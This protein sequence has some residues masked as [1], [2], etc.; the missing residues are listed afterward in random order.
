MSKY[1]QK[2][3]DHIE[4]NPNFIKEASRTFG[5]STIV[6]AVE[7]IKQSN[8]SYLAYTDNGREHT[9]V[10]AVSWAK[11]AEDHGAGEILLTSIDKDGT[12]NGFDLE[13]IKKVSDLVT[14]PVIAHGGAANIFHISASIKDA[15]ADA[16][17][18]ASILHYTVLNNNSS[19]VNNY[20]TEG[21]TEFLKKKGSFK[22]FGKENISKIK[23]QLSKTDIPLSFGF[24]NIPAFLII[25]PITTFMAKI[26]ANA[27]HRIDKK[28]VNKLFG[29][30]LLIVAT[31]FMY[32]YLNI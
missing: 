16:V 25:V 24:I 2:L 18:I 31:K 10:D 32:N 17:A 30:F 5:S 1:Q 15:G 11:L 28:K 13:L 9:G 12:G 4:N 19:L 8:N 22:M 7:A 29:T 3:I 27:M 21:N 6:V 14:I 23:D 20:D 26:G